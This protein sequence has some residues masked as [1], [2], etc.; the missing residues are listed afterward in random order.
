M[1][2]NVK[3]STS[4]F[5]NGRSG[6]GFVLPHIWN[7]YL[8][9]SNMTFRRSRPRLICLASPLVGMRR[10]AGCL[11][12]K[13]QKAAL[14]EASNP[15]GSIHLDDVINAFIALYSDEEA[16]DAQLA[17]V[18]NVHKLYDLMSV[19]DFQMNL[20]NCNSIADRMPGVAPILSPEEL[21]RAFFQAMPHRWQRA[22]LCC[23]DT[24][25]CAIP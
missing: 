25:L 21:K 8:C 20:E 11:S 12:L 6:T 16:R 3:R 24:A 17:Y 1:V 14:L 15:D 4:R 10:L 22:S 7:F 13:R 19:R 9:I 23:G 18:R 5:V 2:R